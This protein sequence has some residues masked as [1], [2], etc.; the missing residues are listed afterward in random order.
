[1]IVIPAEGGA[2]PLAVIGNQNTTP[3]SLTFAELKGIMR[4]DQQRFGNGQKIV[5]A[6]MK[7]STP[8]GNSVVERVLEMSADA[9][10][11]HW[12]AVIFQ[13]KATPPKQ[14]DTEEA[15]RVFVATTEGA[16]G[17]LPSSSVTGE[18]ISQI[19]VDGKKTW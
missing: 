6:V 15:L 5:L 8:T 13:G 14:F 1:M 10:R 18:G 16:I 2:Q 9:F 4:A 12:L 3:A 17:I 7:V 11:K 19:S